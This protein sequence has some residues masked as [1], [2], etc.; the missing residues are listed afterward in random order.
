MEV[1]KVDFKSGNAPELFTKSLKDTG[2]AVLT[3]H[4]I[5]EDLVN[6]V[7]AEWQKFF[8]SDER[9]NY[10]LDVEK[11]DGYVP[12]TQSETAKNNT[13]RD[14][15]EFYHVYPWGRY[16]KSLS[17]LTMQLYQEMS[18]LAAQLL[19][20]IENNTP[21]SVAK[22]FSMPL[23]AMIKNSPATLLRILHYPPLKGDEPER[24]VRAADHEDIN[25]ITLLPAA[26]TT[27][28]QV[29]NTQGRWHDV[30]CD[31]GS[32]AVNIGDMLQM[33]SQRYF[34]STTHRVVN[35][36]GAAAEQSRLSMPLFLHPRP[37]V[38]LSEQHTQRTYLLERLQELGLV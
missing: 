11:Q 15:K 24:A 21:S 32:L 9:F 33:C 27:G 38:K 29:K 7:Y 22:N 37:E 14:L 36:I 4:P 25:L 5:R 34:P 16:P 30:P 13:V 6:R 23:S 12:F 20:W 28:L 31:H 3:N 17:P 10:L 35:P 18:V 2:F 19:Q 1:L 26:T 8:N